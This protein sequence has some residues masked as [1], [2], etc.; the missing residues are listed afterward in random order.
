MGARTFFRCDCSPSVSECLVQSAVEFELHSLLE[1]ISR[2]YIRGGHGS[3][4]YIW[5]LERVGRVTLR[6]DDKFFGRELLGAHGGP[7]KG[8]R[9]RSCS[10]A[11]SDGPR[12][13]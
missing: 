11:T 13:C 3:H 12:F 6:A 8:A 9:Q 10:Q 7:G 5:V 4:E 2:D 1:T